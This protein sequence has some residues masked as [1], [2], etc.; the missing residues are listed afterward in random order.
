MRNQS[1][2]FYIWMLAGGYLVYLGF[3]LLRDGALS[4]E[5]TG[6]M[7]VF[8]WAA[9][10]FFMAFGAFFAVIAVRGLKRLR[11][12]EQ[13]E[14]EKQA[15]EAAQ[16]EDASLQNS[17]GTMSLFDRARIDDEEDDL[18]EEESPGEETEEDP[19]I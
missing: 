18:P 14:A 9:G 1:T 7:L 13:E 12:Q 10:L 16:Q 6:G 15:Q 11:E 4:G 17:E 19:A 2:R 3:K 5:M 8:G